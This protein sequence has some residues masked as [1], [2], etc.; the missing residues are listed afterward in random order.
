[1]GSA[2]G[3]AARLRAWIMRIIMAVVTSFGW[4]ILEIQCPQD[5][6]VLSTPPRCL[7]GQAQ[8]SL[9]SNNGGMP[10]RSFACLDRHATCSIKEAGDSPHG[11]NIESEL[12]DI[13][14]VYT[15]EDNLPIGKT[16]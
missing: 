16:V 14:C 12:G 11:T 5:E 7:H 13:S 15:L 2:G 1:M 8:G 6:S 10:V 3:E 9:V 4:S